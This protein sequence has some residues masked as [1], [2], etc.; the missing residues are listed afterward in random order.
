VLSLKE[1]IMEK[2]ESNIVTFTGYRGEMTKNI[3]EMNADELQVWEKEINQKIR[4]TLFAINMPLVH[5]KD[6]KI[7]AELADG[8]IEIIR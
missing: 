6:G 1:K 8:T 7:V 4:K 5:K 2:E 3:I